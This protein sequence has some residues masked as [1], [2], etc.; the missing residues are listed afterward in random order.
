M[1]IRKRTC[2]AA[3]V[4]LAAVAGCGSGPSRQDGLAAAARARTQLVSEIRGLY[5]KIYH[6]HFAWQLGGM[7][8]EYQGCPTSSRTG[9]LAYYVFFDGL[10]SFSL[11]IDSDMYLRQ[12][13]SLMRAAGW[14]YSHQEPGTGTTDY[15]FT[16]DSMTLRMSVRQ[17]S[18]KT[19]DYSVVTAWG[20]CFDAGPAAGELRSPAHESAF[21]LPHP[22]PLPSSAPASSPSG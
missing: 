21:P 17:T 16:K 3:L 9:E 5:L 2:S 10:Q 15:F 13:M 19:G 7:T 11:H 4:V 18:K 1:E 20:P 8:S 12:A 6:A 22:N 14:R